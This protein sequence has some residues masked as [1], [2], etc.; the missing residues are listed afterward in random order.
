VALGVWIGFGNGLVCADILME[1][2]RAH[3]RTA[4]PIVKFR[5]LRKLRFAKDIKDLSS[6][7]GVQGSLHETGS[8]PNS[9][10][11]LYRC[12]TYDCQEQTS[13]FDLETTM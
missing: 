13:Y 9:N 10:V 7:A 2:R 11:V 8:T 6:T 4:K 5:V 12:V 3:E 1:E